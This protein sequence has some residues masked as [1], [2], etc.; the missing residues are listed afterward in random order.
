M[1][2]VAPAQVEHEEHHPSTRFYWGVGAVMF[3]ITC[4]EVALYYAA[5]PSK[6]QPV[7]LEVT[8]YALSAV[9]FAGVVAFFMHLRFDN[10]LFTAFFVAGLILAAS[11]ILAV[12]AL[13][14]AFGA[15]SVH[16]GEAP[17]AAV[18]PAAGGPAPAAAPATH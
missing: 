10:K 8:L 17:P 9:K 1:Q 18:A 16:E 2:T 7:A 4:V 11:T 13:V 12:L 15:G 5:D 3:V 6:P 14:G